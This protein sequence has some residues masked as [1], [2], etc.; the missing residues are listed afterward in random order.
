MDITGGYRGACVLFAAADLDIF[1]ILDKAPMTSAVVASELGLD[2]RATTI[3]LDSLAAMGLLVKGDSKYSLWPGVSELLTEA[4]GANVL[5]MVRHRSNCLGRWVQLAR[6]VKSGKPVRRR[7]SLRGSG[8]DQAAFIEAMHNSSGPVAAQ[9]VAELGPL[10]FRQLLDVGGAS[11]TW[12]IAFLQ[13]VAGSRATLF[14]LPEVIPMAKRR[15]AEAGLT[16]RVILVGGDFYT[17]DLPRGADFAWL[18]A[19]THQNSREQN[20]RLF[21][22]TYAALD[23]GGVLVLRDVVMDTTRTRPVAGAMFAVNMLVATEGGGTYTFE[24]YRSDL[25]DGGFCD[26]TLLRRDEF[27]NSLIR[28]AKL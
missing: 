18:G 2:A 17:D 19:I 14:D 24:E 23:K 15:V 5:G 20:R 22:R 25:A 1:S 8:A 26:V 4:S 28:A 7:P 10:N 12:T 11:G 6:V 9:I 13:A 16:G 21:A 3:L 27:M